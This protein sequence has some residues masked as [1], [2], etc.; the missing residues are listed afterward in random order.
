MKTTKFSITVCAI[1]LGA[2]LLFAKKPITGNPNQIT[3]RIVAQ[4]HEDVVLTD[5]QQVKM[6]ALVKD[7]IAQINNADDSQIRSIS[8]KHRADMDSLLTP[9][10]RD[11]Q[12]I[13]KN[14]RIETAKKK[15]NK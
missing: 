12:K 10:Q 4:I 2:G 3:N 13:M 1:I 11:Q 15:S 14:Q 6:K 7:Y 8:L 9:T 5:S